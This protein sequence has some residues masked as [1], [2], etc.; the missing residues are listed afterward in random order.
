[1]V[2]FLFFIEQNKITIALATVL[3]IVFATLQTRSLIKEYQ[4]GFPIAIVF[5]YWM[6]YFFCW[7]LALN[8]LFFTLC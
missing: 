7:E 1:M 6:F 2:D 8:C 4:Y 5:L 3:S